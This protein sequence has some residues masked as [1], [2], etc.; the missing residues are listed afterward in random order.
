MTLD[1]P[2]LQLN[3]INY[4]VAS[5][6]RHVGRSQRGQINQPALELPEIASYITE[7]ADI[8]KQYCSYRPWRLSK[9]RVKRPDFAISENV[10]QWAEEVATYAELFMLSHE[11]GH[12]VNALKIARPL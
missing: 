9:P 7:T 5:R 10:R 3:F 11:I 4:T 8:F 12:I 2:N 1:R 6:D